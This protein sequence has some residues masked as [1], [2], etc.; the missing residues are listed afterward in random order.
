MTFKK[1]DSC[2]LE[3]L[4]SYY[5]NT[6]KLNF[7]LRKYFS[8]NKLISKIRIL[9]KKS[10]LKFNTVCWK[11]SIKHSADCREKLCD[12]FGIL[13]ETKWASAVEITVIATN[14]DKIPCQFLWINKYK[15]PWENPWKYRL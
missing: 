11:V 9:S 3:F 15:L 10:I 6:N 1:L 5:G 4:A 12:L 2:T 8:L 14:E 7:Q 13:R